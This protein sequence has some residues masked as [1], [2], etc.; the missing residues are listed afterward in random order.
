M[1]KQPHRYFNSIS[2]LFNLKNV[3]GVLV[4]L[5]EDNLLKNTLSK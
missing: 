5:S 2:T 1:K 3:N 4:D